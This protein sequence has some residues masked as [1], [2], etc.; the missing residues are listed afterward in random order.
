[1]DLEVLIIVGKKGRLFLFTLLFSLSALGNSADID[2]FGTYEE[3][4]LVAFYGLFFGKDVK[5]HNP[6]DFSNSEDPNKRDTVSALLESSKDTVLGSVIQS[7]VDSLESRT[8]DSGTVLVSFQVPGGKITYACHSDDFPWKARENHCIACQ[9]K[10]GIE[11]IEFSDD[12]IFSVKY[13]C[14]AFR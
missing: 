4:A 6:T 12:L 1:M 8:T 5:D 9:T 10:T 14:S 13:S 11:R 3:T 2:S 7:S